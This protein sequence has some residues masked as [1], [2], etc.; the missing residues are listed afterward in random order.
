MRIGYQPHST[1]AVKVVTD[2]SL[3]ARNADATRS[4][5]AVLPEPPVSLPLHCTVCHRLGV[6]PVGETLI[7]ILVSSPRREVVEGGHIQ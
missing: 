4:K 3:S 2:V 6:V 1:M 5:H 7:I